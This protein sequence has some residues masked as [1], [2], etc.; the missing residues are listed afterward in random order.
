MST[1][2]DLSSWGVK[3]IRTPLG[4]VWKAKHS[5]GTKLRCGLPAGLK[6]NAEADAVAA[7]ERYE[8]GEDVEQVDGD[9]LAERVHGRNG[10]LDRS[11]A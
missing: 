4:W 6:R 2:P 7:L 3:F 11:S 5:D 1:R 10:V 9:G 8:L